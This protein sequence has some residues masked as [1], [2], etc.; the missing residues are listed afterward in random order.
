MMHLGH[1]QD[2]YEATKMDSANL[3]LVFA[4]NLLRQEVDDISSII[5]TGK[6]SS[7]IDTLV[8]Q[9]EW[10]FD[11]YPAEEEEEEEEQ[12]QQ[13]GVAVRE[14]PGELED[15]VP[16][17]PIQTQ[18]EFENDVVLEDSPPGYHEGPRATIAVTDVKS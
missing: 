14:D 1:V 16:D 6:Q 7:I 8:E 11:P 9:R 3:A 2:Q 17:T 13:G 12:Q 18:E 5:N 10:V 4:P 15:Q